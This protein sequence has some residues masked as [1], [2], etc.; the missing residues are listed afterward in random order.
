MAEEP[1]KLGLADSD[2]Y[3]GS[4]QIWPQNADLRFRSS[5]WGWTKLSLKASCQ[6]GGIKGSAR[7]AAKDWLVAQAYSPWIIFL[8]TLVLDEKVH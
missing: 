8:I 2:L 1:Q 4:A 7:A 6:G 3:L 5:R